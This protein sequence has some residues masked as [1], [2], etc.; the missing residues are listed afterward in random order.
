M[1]IHE[2]IKKAKDDEHIKFRLMNRDDLELT[3]LDAYYGMF[4]C[5]KLEDNQMIMT[6]QLIQIFGERQEYEII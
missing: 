6:S 4:K 2:V 1:L 5:N 3:V